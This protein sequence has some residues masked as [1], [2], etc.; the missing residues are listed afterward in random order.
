[1]LIGEIRFLILPNRSPRV[2]P[3]GDRGGETL[4]RLAA[5]PPPASPPPHRPGGAANKAR[6]VCIV[7]GGRSLRWVR[8]RW[9]GSTVSF[10]VPL[11]T[12]DGVA[13]GKG[14]FPGGSLGGGLLESRAVALG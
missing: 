2:A 11:A 10:S 1:M 8:H 14:G 4:V 3:P 12:S 13:S 5:G 9:G 6:D 7:Y